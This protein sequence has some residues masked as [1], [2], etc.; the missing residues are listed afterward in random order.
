METANVHA[1]PGTSPGRSASPTRRAGTRTAGCLI[2]YDVLKIVA[3]LGVVQFHAGGPKLWYSGM[4]LFLFFLGYPAGRAESLKTAIRVRTQRLLLPW[5]LWCAVYYALELYRG[6]AWLPGEPLDPLRLLVGPVIHLWFLPFAFATGVALTALRP[7]WPVALPQ[8]LLLLVLLTSLCLWLNLVIT[9]P[10]PP[11]SQWL[12][13]LPMVL[14]GF[15]ASRYRKPRDQ[16]AVA[17]AVVALAGIALLMGYRSEP[18]QLLLVYPICVA[19]TQWRTR[20]VPVLRWLGNM[21][22]GIYI[23]HPVAIL[24]MW[25]IAPQVAGSPFLLG[26]SAFLLSLALVALLRRWPPARRVL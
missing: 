11:V 7:V 23:V 4:V 9:P 8:S 6:S 13:A 3:A 15:T 17:G 20:P 18:F 2:L 10:L 24:A 19:A 21:A 16:A 26:S 5:L 1:A 14:I 25:K 22:M 12:I